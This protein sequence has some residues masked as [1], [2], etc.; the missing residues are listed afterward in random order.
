MKTMSV[1]ELK[2]QFSAVLDQIKHGETFVICHGRRRE[3]IAAL[4]PYRQITTS[5]RP[6][7]LLQGHASCVIH[8]DFELDDDQFL[9]Q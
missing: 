9:K 3:K 1:G 7:G 8:D 5:E 6:L 2:A 4:I